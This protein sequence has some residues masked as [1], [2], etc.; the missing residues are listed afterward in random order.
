[1]VFA[2]QNILVK[3]LLI[4]VLAS[5]FA[6]GQEKTRHSHNQNAKST[7]A[8]KEGVFGG[9][10]AKQFKAFKNTIMGPLPSDDT[11]AP[12]DLASGNNPPRKPR[13][14]TI[15]PFSKRR[16]PVVP[17][18]SQR[19][20]GPSIEPPIS[21]EES[22]SS[23]AE[24]LRYMRNGVTADDESEATTIDS[25]DEATE[26]NETYVSSQPA[27]SDK[28]SSR[29]RTPTTT[30]QASSDASERTTTKAPATK[31]DTLEVSKPV[32]TKAG[33]TQTPAS[34]EDA[35]PKV[36]RKAI[37][38][39]DPIAVPPAPAE[40]APTASAPPVVQSTKAAQL[41]SSSGASTGVGAQSFASQGLAPPSSLAPAKDAGMRMGMPQVRIDCLGPSAVQINVP[42]TY[43]VRATNEG[44]ENLPGLLVR[45]AIPSSIK[46]V[47]A[48][49]VDGETENET[50][51]NEVAVVWQV[52][53]LAAG[54]SKVLA[55]SIE[56]LKPEE[57]QLDF[58]WT[59][60]P[61]VGRMPIQVQQPQLSV[62]LDGASE[63]LYG[64][65]ENYKLR[66]RNPGTAPVRNVTVA[67]AAESFGRSEAVV[68]DIPPGEERTMEVEL[69]F[70]QTGD[71]RITVDGRSETSGL[72]ASSV[73]NVNVRRADIVAEW[74]VPPEQFPNM[75]SDYQLNIVNNGAV[76]CEQLKCVVMLPQGAQVVQLPKGM[77]QDGGK[78]SWQIPRL[79]PQEKV[80]F[81]WQM[82]LSD[83]GE[84]I[85]QFQSLGSA[86]GKAESTATV[87][88]ESVSD[89]KLSVIDPVA[90][91]PVG[92]PVEYVLVIQN[93][94]TKPAT[95]VRVVA[96]FS[97]GIEPEEAK[98]HA[99]QIVP[100]QVLFDPIPLIAPG[101]E[102][103]LSVFAKAAES[104]THRFRAEVTSE[105]S[106]AQLIQEES[107]R[108][109]ATTRTDSSSS[110]RR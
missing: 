40:P 53:G 83:E 108:Y 32:S 5:G 89:L 97:N 16:V 101:K 10:I 22:V 45:V 77:T 46:L 60:L 66:V 36:S 106:D 56:A 109:L 59:V 73:V 76:P 64:R 4:G 74:V 42:T 33:P 75:E 110:L 99:S 12:E 78:I 18:P 25:S 43:Q 90:P 95:A 8:K 19:D 28:S 6:V 3:S 52:D 35:F 81:V 88:V 87:R 41:P 47:S 38:K 9:T 65:P 37:V 39:E 71:I 7:P 63:T 107:T 85:L 54:Q 15:E 50:T 34:V 104:G 80:N 92:K 61:M 27:I 17:G 26:E 30:P 49:S 103:R 102:V 29:R 31:V 44:P 93:R 48:S 91:A 14:P 79:S 62:A 72:T 11:E 86:G 21:D 20:A 1:M 24:R 55:L 69:T 100:G 2:S 58:E 98:G 57:F 67:V 68:G 84:N 82:K 23:A 94:G 13:T 70:Q 51:P 96:Q 105:D